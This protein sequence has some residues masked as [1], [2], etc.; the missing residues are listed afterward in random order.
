MHNVDVQERLYNQQL[1]VH[2]AIGSNKLRTRIVRTTLQPTTLRLHMHSDI[3]SNKL[4]TRIV[5][6]TLQ[7][8]NFT[9]SHA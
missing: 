2:S 5:R 9:T 7:T 1:H 8:N 4:R 6:A 3:G